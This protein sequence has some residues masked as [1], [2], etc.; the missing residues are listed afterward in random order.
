M[1]PIQQIQSKQQKK[2]STK[3]LVPLTP[4][5]QEMLHHV[6]TRLDRR[7]NTWYRIFWYG[8]LQGAGAVV[9]AAL[10]IFITALILHLFGFNESAEAIKLY[11][12]YGQL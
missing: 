4:I 10:L 5:T 7:F 12:R 3:P 1:E 2:T 9:G 8:M 11:G 6:L